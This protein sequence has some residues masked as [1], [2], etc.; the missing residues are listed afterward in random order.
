MK[1][2][3]MYT[4]ILILAIFNGCEHEKEHEHDDHSHDDSDS[5]AS[6]LNR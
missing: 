6:I 2:L 1:Q 4:L 3:T 5:T